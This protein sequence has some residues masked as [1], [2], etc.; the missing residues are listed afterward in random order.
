MARWP[1]PARLGRRACVVAARPAG[2]GAP[3]GRLDNGGR[4]L[5]IRGHCEATETGGVACGV[6][7]RARRRLRW[8]LRALSA[9]VA[10]WPGG[11]PAGRRRQRR[12][13]R[14]ETVP[15]LPPAARADG[16]R[17]RTRCGQA[18][19]EKMEASEKGGHG[20]GR[21]RTRGRGPARAGWC[22]E[23][24]GEQEAP[25]RLRP[26]AHARMGPAGD[27]STREGPAKRMSPSLALFTSVVELH[28]RLLWKVSKIRLDHD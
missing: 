16:G 5:V 13:G 22:G 26:A 25:P 18:G 9:L 14:W 20:S 1:T 3:E 6:P 10:W 27:A 28:M 2:G 8:W 11:A 4:W 21:R 17:R 19:A 24:G 7:A 15:R 23:G 12:R